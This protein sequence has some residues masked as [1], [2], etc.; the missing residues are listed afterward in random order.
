MKVTPSGAHVGA[1]IEG[2]DLSQ[3]LDDT[4]FADIEAAFD[5]HAVIVFRNQSISPCDQLRFSERFGD[6]EINAFSKFALDGYPGILKVSNIKEDGQDIGYA[7]AG[8]D[9]HSDM[10]YTA[11]PPAPP[12][13]TRWKSPLRMTT[14]WAHFVRKCARGLRITV[15][16]AQIIAPGPMC[17]TSL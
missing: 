15:E 1:E 3:G 13:C 6:L 4:T 8:T 10:S 11:T 9:W 5:K 17:T 16:C 2:V 7:D 14:P 12:C